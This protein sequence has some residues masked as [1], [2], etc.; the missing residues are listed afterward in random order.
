MVDIEAS[1][2]IVADDIAKLNA[3]SAFTMEQPTWMQR[4]RQVPPKPPLSTAPAV[5]D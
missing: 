5:T 4:I 2:G 3:V 1:P